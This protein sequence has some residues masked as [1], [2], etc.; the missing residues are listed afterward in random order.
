[1]SHRLAYDKGKGLREHLYS[2]AEGDAPGKRGWFETFV[3]TIGSKDIVVKATNKNPNAKK[4]ISDRIDSLR[5]PEYDEIF[6]TY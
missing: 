3:D 6:N 5:A 4:I 2:L 1:M